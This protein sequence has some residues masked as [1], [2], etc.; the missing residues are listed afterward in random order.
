MAV[1]Q[2]CV[3]LVATLSDAWQDRNGKID[4]VEFGR[5]FGL[6]SDVFL[7]RLINIWDTVRSR[8]IDSA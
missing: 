7:D 8:H 2:I 3:P 5:M 6:P 4:S 1:I